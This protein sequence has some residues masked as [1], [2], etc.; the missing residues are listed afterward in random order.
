M[1]STQNQFRCFFRLAFESPN[2][3]VPQKIPKIFS[4][5]FIEKNFKNVFNH[6]KKKH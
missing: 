2:Q 5:P 4:V 1:N 3:K 6:C